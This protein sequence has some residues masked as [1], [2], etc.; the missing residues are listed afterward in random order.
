MDNSKSITVALA[1]NPNSGKTYLFNDLVGAN[2]KVGNFSGVT[3]EKIEGFVNYNG[4]K[5]RVIDLPGTYSLTAYSPEEVVTRDYIIEEKPDV[6][7]NVV[8]GTNLERNLYLTTQL[9]EIETDILIA[10]NMFDEVLKLGIEIK[11]K[12]LQTLLGSHVVPTSARKRTGIESLLDH[13]VRI[14][15]GTITIAKN[16]LSYQNGLEERIEIL[17]NILSK[18][19]ELA[20]KYPC[21]WLAIKLFENDKI[22]YQLVKER[23]VWI[24]AYKHLMETNSYLESRY[25]EDSE[26]VI[27][28][29]R[30]S[31]IKGAIK[32]TVR[33][34]QKGKRTVTEVLDKILINRVTGLPV[35]LLFMWGT[36][37]LVFKVGEYPVF[38]LEE[39]FSWLRGFVGDAINNESVK[40]IVV[41]G[42][43]GGVG[44]VIVFL[45]NILFLFFALS[46]LE[47]TGY[48]ARAAFV[49]DKIMHIFGLHGKSA[50]SMITGFGC[51]VPAFMAT[52]TLKGKSDRIT[53]LLIIPFMSC[54]A[55]LP[56][57]I[58]IIGAFFSTGIAGN[59]LFAIYIFG[60]I[61]ALLSAKLFKV[62]IF[63]GKSEPFVMELPPY[64]L[65]SFKSLLYQMWH[66]AAMYLRK[67]ATIILLASVI[68]WLGS[69]FPKD[70]KV[71]QEYQSKKE[72]VNLNNNLTEDQKKDKI[73]LL[74][75]EEAGIQIKRSIIG[76]IGTAIEPVIKPLGFD[77]KIG[78]SLL[79]GFAAKEIVVST[80]G[81][82]HS[83]GEVDDEEPTS[84]QEKIGNDP[85]YSIATAIAFL[86]FVLLYVPCIAATIVFHREAGAWKWTLFYIFYSVAIAW[87]MAYA[88]FNITNLIL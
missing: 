4:Y 36:F 16:K 40:S 75:A 68:I 27:T 2:Q 34:T 37:Q 60:V 18:D 14:Y 58:L 39:F 23:P 73:K 6:V 64:R 24:K 22:I 85:S 21:R 26:L 42:I 28:E 50:I 87:I 63:K 70:K 31:F 76:R 49:I 81:T 83:L 56:V 55:K 74:K 61:I 48:M 13:I 71:S 52:R 35:F 69:N 59:L 15:E 20:S 67:A 33:E 78:I 46:F 1:G 25:H 57:Y 79:S 45:P 54:G 30:H 47:G 82:L 77:W 19:H 7:V 11:I 43:I 41:D 65:P 86:I 84:L 38:W 72:V 10:L 66:K 62:V 9:M 88:G 51:S 5:I 80:M 3:V 44:G 53:T 29:N 8:D 17:A 12:H 32:E